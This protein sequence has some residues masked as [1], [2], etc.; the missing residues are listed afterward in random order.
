MGKFG[1]IDS[2]DTR[3]GK[4]PLVP[5]GGWAEGSAC[6]DT[7][8]RTP[9][10]A[11]GILELLKFWSTLATALAETSA[12]AKVAI[13]DTM[14]PTKQSK[15]KQLGCVVLLSVEKPPPPH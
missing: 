6:A 12:V 1:E 8:A 15:I 10:G 9:I 5:M 7:G 3:A 11:S 14:Q 4:F 13:I 2:A